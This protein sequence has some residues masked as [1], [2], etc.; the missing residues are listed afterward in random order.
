M[1]ISNPKKVVVAA[2][3]QT[4]H[5]EKG[6]SLKKNPTDVAISV[7]TLFQ[8]KLTEKQK[9]CLETRYV[10]ENERRKAYKAIFRKGSFC[11]MSG[12]LTKE[13]QKTVF[14]VDDFIGTD[15]AALE[16]AKKN[17]NENPNVLRS[18]I[19]E[20]GGF[21]LD[22]SSK[23]LG[24]DSELSN[25][26]TRILRQWLVDHNLPYDLDFAWAIKTFF[27]ARAANRS[28]KTGKKLS[29]LGLLK[30]NP[31]M[32]TD[33]SSEL[34]VN[35]LLKAFASCNDLKI[36]TEMELL[37]RV[38]EVLFRAANEGHSCLP[39]SYIANRPEIA[40]LMDDLKIPQNGRSQKITDIVSR[41]SEYRTSDIIFSFKD[42]EPA[43]INL[44]NY[45]EKKFLPCKDLDKDELKAFNRGRVVPTWRVG[46]FGRFA[47]LRQLYFS[48]R[49]IA[50]SL[51]NHIHS[52]FKPIPW[53]KKYGIGLNEEQI[54]AVKMALSNA[55]SV[56][57][58]GAGTGKTHVI[59]HIAHIAEK[60]GKKTVI[61]APT[62]TAAANACRDK[63]SLNY[64]TIH[65]FAKISFDSDDLGTP[66]F[67]PHVDEIG[68]NA[69]IIVD[70]M[71]MCTVIML[72]RLFKALKESPDAQIVF[73]GDEAQLP[74]VGANCFQA[75]T[76]QL[77]GD[78]IPV[79]RLVQNYRAR[80]A[81]QTF[82]N[83]IRDGIFKLPESKKIQ[84]IESSAK[85]FL[86]E[87]IPILRFEDT[88]IL[89]NTRKEQDR[90]N[91]IL[92]PLAA[93]ATLPIHFP[94]QDGDTVTLN[95]FVGDPVVATRN[96][97]YDIVDSDESQDSLFPASTRELRHHDRHE[98]VYNGTFG[99]IES[100]SEDTGTV[101]IRLFPPEA[102]KNGFLLPYNVAELPLLFDVAYCITA[103]KAQGQERDVVIFVAED[104]ASNLHRSLLYT[105]V[106]RARKSLYLIGNT[107]LFSNAT[108]NVKEIPL[109][110]LPY[111]YS[112]KKSQ[113]EE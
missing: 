107:D 66:D 21:S 9:N 56:I 54:A 110:L 11:Y 25:T 97:Y 45:Y 6:E 95:F 57:L 4:V 86:S 69:M 10:F 90:L 68:R 94:N 75:F 77:Y 76:E 89:T 37:A 5:L 17:L 80:N 53:K 101:Y 102:P 40:H 59:Q 44:S 38:S 55:V 99:R 12:T 73:V 14:L 70:E 104:Q 33:F 18:Q 50:D 62:A 16:M 47:Y 23:F 46:K 3:I 27:C 65:R 105:V 52:E 98:S 51:Y 79:T 48:E 96:D 35:R 49:Y 26:E 67:S 83:N 78:D 112:L 41:E 13:G 111:R 22:S 87:N 43:L 88:L 113:M 15:K 64:F 92:R 82:A 61:L 71:S 74:A 109:S 81:L 34:S 72:A 58:G 42:I 19:I 84:I 108:K 20:A 31:L 32:L 60:A 93:L 85:S 1:A 36:T 106:S 2:R 63:K 39:L 103:H 24:I 30:K 8:G 28:R 29:V 91:K 7:E 100:F